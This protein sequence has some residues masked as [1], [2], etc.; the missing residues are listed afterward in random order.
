MALGLSSCTLSGGFG[1]HD[2]SFDSEYREDNLVGWFQGDVP[3]TDNINLYA[4]HESMPKYNE[5]DNGR[6]GG[7]GV[8]T[9]GISGH[10]DIG[11]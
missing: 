11:K 10:I 1:L 5:Q 9:F 6:G 4:R 3:V 8:N 2:R 7:Y